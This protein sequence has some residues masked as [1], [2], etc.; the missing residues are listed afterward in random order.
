MASQ[1]LSYIRV[2]HRIINF[3][4][5]LLPG[6]Y[7]NIFLTNLRG[8]YGAQKSLEILSLISD[9]FLAHKDV[10]SF[11]YKIVVEHIL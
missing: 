10:G 9:T 1:V 8:D 6:L 5:I 4:K 11:I 2:I 3:L 7:L